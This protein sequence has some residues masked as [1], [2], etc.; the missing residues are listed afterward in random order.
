MPRLKLEYQVSRA[1]LFR[2]VGQYFAQHQAALAD[3][4]TGQPLFL[5][6]TGSAPFQP[7]AAQIVNDFRNDFLFS[8]KPTPGTV[9]FMRYGPSLS[10]PAAFH[11]QTLSPTSD[12]FFSK[13]TSLFLLAI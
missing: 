6:P 9:C 8:Y 13:I 5:S 4:R 7:A 12:G 1:I 2:Y 10:E 11:F 3:P